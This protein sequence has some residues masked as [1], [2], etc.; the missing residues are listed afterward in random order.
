MF[1][2]GVQF[3]PSGATGLLDEKI[4]LQNSTEAHVEIAKEESILSVLTQSQFILTVFSSFMLGFALQL[5][6]H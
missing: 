2:L 3:L 6:L 5:A 4:V 1:K